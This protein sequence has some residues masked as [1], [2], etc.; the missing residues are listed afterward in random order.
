[1]P[2]GPRPDP[3]N[4][5]CKLVF[6]GTF[7]SASWANVMWLYLTGSGEIVHDDLLDLAGG[8]S[9]AYSDNF[10]PLLSSASTLKA[11]QTVL[12]F[13]GD[14]FDAIVPV[15]VPGSAVLTQNFPA[16]VSLCI[17]WKIAS[18]Y[19]GGHP[20]TYL[21]GHGTPQQASTTQWTTTYADAAVSA[22]TGFH[23]DLEGLGPIGSGITT[24]EHG[25]ISFQ[26]AGSWRSPP[27]FRRINDAVVDQR[28][29][30]QRRRLGRDVPA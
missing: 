1:M 19:R 10:M 3:P 5:S 22:A 15:S 17:S 23:N 9:T 11:C 25:I 21:C 29:D 8:A 14:V 30:T 6:Y 16:N 26:S 13:D 2:T 12:Y 24:V 27:I 28:M 18:H 20:R 4:R 7:G